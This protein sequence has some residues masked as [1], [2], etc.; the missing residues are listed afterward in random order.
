[1]D[2]LEQ[3]SRFSHARVRDRSIDELLGLA[4]GITA[5]GQVN[6]S[7][8][9]FLQRWMI[10]ASGLQDDPVFSILYNR[11][12]SY[13]ADGELDQEEAED[14]FDMLRALTGEDG[15]VHQYRRPTDLPL[16]DPFPNVIFPEKNFVFTGV[17]AYGPRKECE[18][19][20]TE[21][22]GS[23]RGGLSK[24]VD[25]LVIGTIANEH[26]MYSSYGRKIERAIELREQGHGVAI[27]NEDHFM[28]HA[29]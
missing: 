2:E 29:I 27:I 7:E 20:V 1:M 24:K 3:L 15:K 22:G 10:Q 26:W 8:A 14:L 23:C 12:G 18:L 17:M 16:D 6:K 5:D 19:L 25:Y 4:R 13:L 21:H 9:E 28:R 11:I